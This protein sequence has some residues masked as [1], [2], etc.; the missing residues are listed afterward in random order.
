MDLSKLKNYFL[1]IM[2]GC[3]VAAGVIAVTTVLTGHFNEIFGKSLLTILL[4]AI[5][6]LVSFGYIDLN[7]KNKSVNDLTFFH[8]TTFVL[9]VLSF[10]TSIFGVW[11]VMSGDLVAKL[12]ATYVILLFAVLHGETL[13]KMIN[14][15]STIDNVVRVN[16]VFMVVV[17]LLIVPV[18]YASD[19]A[20]LGDFYYRILAAFGIIDAIL[21]LVAIILNKLYLQK[22]PKVNP[23]LFGN[24]PI[25]LGAT[26]P[27]AAPAAPAA[28]PKK[29][30]NILV[31]ILIVFL[32][33][34]L[35]AGLVFA[36]IGREAAK[37]IN[38][39]E[40][41][42]TTSQ[43]NLAPSTPGGNYSTN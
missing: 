31:V 23:T 14:N 2:I 22:H 40:T 42:H 21:T 34:Q 43:V 24:T 9:I 29:G 33:F 35:V 5:H 17:V 19:P 15:D 37:N 12:Y 6:A 4:I 1:K 13:S 10:V 39:A 32:G 30:M 20:S 36:V 41:K 7:E 28:Q 26:A 11:G 38:K 27:A 16:Y 18:I 25:T 8:N 3:L